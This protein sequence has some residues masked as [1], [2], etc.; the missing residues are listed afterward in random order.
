MCSFPRTRAALTRTFRSEKISTE[1]PGQHLAP[2]RPAVSLALNLRRLNGQTLDCE[3]PIADEVSALVLKSL[4]TRVRFKDTDIA[5]IWRCL[6]IAYAAS[7]RPGT[8]PVAPARMPPRLSGLSSVPEMAMLCKHLLVSSTS[9]KWP[10]TSVIP[11]CE[12]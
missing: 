2:A 7:L 10:P 3:L 6:E 11:A 1:V 4:A 8:L 12:R 9:Q 5:D